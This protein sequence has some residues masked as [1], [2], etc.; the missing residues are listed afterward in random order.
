MHERPH[1]KTRCVAD[2]R[3]F[4]VM[5]VRVCVSVRL[6]S[7]A[8]LTEVGRAVGRRRGVG[9]V[10]DGGGGFMR[11]QRCVSSAVILLSVTCCSH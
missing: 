2:R 4:G 1:G 8:A 3:C 5:H 7:C 10:V 6:F 11:P 9:H